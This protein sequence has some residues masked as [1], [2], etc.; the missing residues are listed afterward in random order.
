MVRQ[1][2]TASKRIPLPVGSR[3]EGVMTLAAVEKITISIPG[4]VAAAARTRARDEFGGNMSAYITDL[5]RKA[6]IQAAIHRLI[7]Y[8]DALVGDG[9]IGDLAA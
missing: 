3:Y 5:M 9:A 2:E 1:G 7:P 4:D 8:R 6:E